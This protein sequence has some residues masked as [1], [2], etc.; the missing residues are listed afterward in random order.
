M[1]KLLLTITLLGSLLSYSQDLTVNGIPI[2]ELD[3]E[4]I[5]INAENKLL[6]PFQAKIY[7]DYGQIARI[8]DIK[9]GYVLDENG[10]QFSFNGIMGAVNL[11]TENGYIIDH[12]YYDGD[13]KSINYLMKKSN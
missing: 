9:K 4:Y 6:K 13:S 7:I 3:A 2:S 11:L 1:K 10:K 5:R 12:I 8:K